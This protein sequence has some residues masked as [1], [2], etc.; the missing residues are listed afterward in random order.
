MS[1]DSRTVH[2]EFAIAY[3]A[4]NDSAAVA[5]L[6][7]VHDCFYLALYAALAARSRFAQNVDD[8]SAKS[9][10]IG[11]R[12]LVGGETTI[13]IGAGDVGVAL[14][15]IEDTRGADAT[16]SLTGGSGE[17]DFGELPSS[18]KVVPSRE[19]FYLS[20]SPRDAELYCVDAAHK[21]FC[22]TGVVLPNGAGPARGINRCPCL[23]F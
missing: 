4:R 15:A 2:D 12:A 23:P 8:L 7:Y 6:D 16:I 19:G 20:P 18:E 13:A 5:G 21:S 1:S 22:D 9:I 3:A 10:M 17:L 14:A 11:L